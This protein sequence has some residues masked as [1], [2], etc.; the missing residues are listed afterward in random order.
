MAVSTTAPRFGCIR[1]D[2]TVT[3]KLTPSVV[4]CRSP[5]ASHDH[6]SQSRRF[7]LSSSSATLSSKS[8]SAR[9]LRSA[10][11]HPGR[12]RSQRSTVVRVLAKAQGKLVTALG[13]GGAGKTT[14]SIALAKH[15]AAQGKKVLLVLQSEDQNA[16][17]LLSMPLP[18]GATPQNVEG[19]LDMLRAFG[20]SLLEEPWKGIR[21]TEAQLAFTGGLL[22]EMTAE[23]LPMV[24]G[25]DVFTVLGVLRKFTLQYDVVVYDGPSSSEVLR[26]VAAPASLQWYLTRLKTAF[27]RTE[28]GRI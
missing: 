27:E 3:R 6:A 10:S 22:D 8:Y 25:M 5:V 21:E 24:P 17:D 23:E 14:V 11:Q 7:A 18:K 9:Q 15:F 20:A 2:V 26:L 28:P 4:A 16:E 19:N 12:A 13:K 1:S